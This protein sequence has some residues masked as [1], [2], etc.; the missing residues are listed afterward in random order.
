MILF[1]P[2]R[3]FILLKY[4]Q[5]NKKQKSKRKKK[6]K[7]KSNLSEKESLNIKNKSSGKMKEQQLHSLTDFL[8]NIFIPFYNFYF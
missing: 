6:K 3:F 8:H 4:F 1:N 7:E 5:T 2:A